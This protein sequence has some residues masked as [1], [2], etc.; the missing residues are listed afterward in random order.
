MNA[1]PCPP[2]D[3]LLMH[4]VIILNCIFFFFI[5]MFMTEPSS[6]YGVEGFCVCVCVLH[7]IEA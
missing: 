3:Y 1:A 5:A 4:T 2:L 6:G 7:C